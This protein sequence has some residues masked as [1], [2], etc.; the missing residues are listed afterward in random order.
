M[1]IQGA[2][3]RFFGQHVGRVINC[4]TRYID[5]GMRPSCAPIII[6]ICTIVPIPCGIYRLTGE[7]CVKCS[8]YVF[9]LK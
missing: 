5:V 4:I 2:V 3:C 8:R 6:H 7:M 1:Q 9:E